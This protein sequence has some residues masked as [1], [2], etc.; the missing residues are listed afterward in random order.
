MS[1]V[2]TMSLQPTATRD[3][4]I[5]DAQLADELPGG[6]GRTDTTVED[7]AAQVHVDGS[8]GTSENYEDDEFEDDYADDDFEDEYN[9][10]TFQDMSTKEDAQ[11]GMADGPATQPD[12]QGAVCSCKPSPARNPFEH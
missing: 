1:Q 3:R 6:A 4:T 10:G 9:D 5:I 12:R 2:T 11:E 7:V 8:L